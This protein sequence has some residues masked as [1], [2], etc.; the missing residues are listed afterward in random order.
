MPMP[1]VRALVFLW[2][3]GLAATQAVHAQVPVTVTSDI[4][5]TVN[6]IETIA[7]WMEQLAAMNRQLDQMKQL[8]GTLQGTRNMGSLLN[9]QLLNQYL[10]EDYAAAART[11][12]QGGGSFGA[13]PGAIEDIV[14]ASQV[15]S[16]T[17]L[18]ADAAARKQC[19]EQW[20]RLALPKHVGDMAYR[21]AAENIRNLQT[22]VNSI[23]AS[24]DQKTIAEVQ[25]RIQVE[26][27]RMQNEQVKLSTIRT[28]QEADVQLRKQATADA[29]NA[30]L[31]RG[32]AG[33]VR[34]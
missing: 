31:V 7:K 1:K 32:A 23:N 12:Q 15:R 16:C 2:A 26:T 29:F 14:R 18:N 17:E 8:Y 13:N 22:F 28:M 20:Q 34:F 30:R 24:T 11:L 25:A 5:A 6:Q 27:V 19:T 3:T 10:P 33:G 21:K 4:P 9:G